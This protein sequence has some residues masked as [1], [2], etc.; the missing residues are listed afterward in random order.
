MRPAWLPA[1]FEAP[2]DLVGAS[3]PHKR[4]AT[5]ASWS[6]YFRSRIQYRSIKREIFLSAKVI[7]VDA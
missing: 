4:K 5:I 3:N 2:H 7:S 1:H 6:R